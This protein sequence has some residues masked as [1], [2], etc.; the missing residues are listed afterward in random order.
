[1]DADDAPGHSLTLAPYTTLFRSLAPIQTRL[2][3]RRIHLAGSIIKILTCVCYLDFHHPKMLPPEW[4]VMR[5]KMERFM[6]N[7]LLIQKY[8]SEEHTSELQS[9]A[10]LVCC[11]LLE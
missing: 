1:H 10:K 7:G 8:R 2:L 5:K 6:G 4:Q 11:P 3:C 9:R